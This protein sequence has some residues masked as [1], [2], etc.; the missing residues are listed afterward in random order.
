MNIRITKKVFVVGLLLLAFTILLSS[1][2]S[3][4]KT[5]NITLVAEDI[6]WDQELIE[7][8]VGETVNL[9]LRNDGVLDHN[10]VAKDLDLN[11]F[12][13]PGDSQVLSFVVTQAGSLIYICDIPG[14]EEAGMAGEFIV[15]E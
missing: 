4:P 3:E 13:S 15:S 9:T 5:R 8:K 1:C 10:F 6:L 11:V 12:L 14:H 2:S 7:L